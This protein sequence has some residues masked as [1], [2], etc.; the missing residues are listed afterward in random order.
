MLISET[1]DPVTPEINGRKLA[2]AMG[3][4]ARLLV[5]HGYGHSS[6]KN[7]SRCTDDTIRTLLLDGKINDQAITHCYADEKP[8]PAGGEKQFGHDDF[9]S[10][11]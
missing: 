11:L 10:H 5:H 2:L 6:A 9:A 3:D 8:Y 4:N 7:P 1:H